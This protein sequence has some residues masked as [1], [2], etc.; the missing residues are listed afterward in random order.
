MSI[1]HLL[2]CECLVYYRIPSGIPGLCPLIGSSTPRAVTIR[3]S[4]D[5]LL[6]LL[7]TVPPG[8][9]VSREH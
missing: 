2:L 3:M 4:A 7:G 1:G 5:L 8:E 6:P 9:G